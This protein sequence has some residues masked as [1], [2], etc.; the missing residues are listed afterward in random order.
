MLRVG[1]V[2][3]GFMGV[4][5]SDAYA[6]IPDVQIAGFVGRSEAN[7]KRLAEKHKTKDYPTLE[8][9]LA[10]EQLDAVDI[11]TPTPLNVEMVKV[12]AQAG[13]PILLEKPI[14]R[15]LKEADEIIRTAKKRKALLMVAH[16]LRFW[17]EYVTIRKI[18]DEGQIGKVLSASA[19]RMCQNPK[20]TAW[21]ADPSQSGGALVTLGIH[22]FDFCN[23][24]F[25]APKSAYALGTRGPQG[26]WDDAT[27][28]VRY[29][30]GVE[31]CFKAS[32]AMPEA[33]PFTMA[34]RAVGERGA[35][36]YLFKA[37]HNIENKA[38]WRDEFFLYRDGK[39]TLP[40]VEKKDAF[41]AEIE[42]FLACVREKK[43]PTHG[44]PE[45][46]RLALKVALAC[47]AALEDGR[48][49]KV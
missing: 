25:G 45:Q 6:K 2:G 28:L 7:R 49:K 46:A 10:A 12:A 44:R 42:H 18:L 8:A 34:F 33:F 48:P 39:M 47:R 3:S 36:D 21:Y 26:G 17:P 11:C 5:H 1:I 15:D 16:V 35:I 27:S 30:S 43:E 40:Q 19:T 29:E 23:S 20:W 38:D 13:K 37:G 32:I 4:T 22:D 31:V 14:A 24:A 41:L 9:M